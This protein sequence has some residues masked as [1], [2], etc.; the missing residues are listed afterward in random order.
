M[1]LIK[2]WILIPAA[3]AALF[4]LPL[5]CASAPEQ[6]AE[7][8]VKEAVTETQ[9]QTTQG[10]EKPEPTSE[11]MEA[12]KKTAL[13][14]REKAVAAKAPKAVKELFTEGEELMASAESFGTGKDYTNAAAEYTKAA[15]VFED[16]STQADK[17]RMEAI[18]A[19]KAAD[20]AI[21]NVEKNADEAVKASSEGDQ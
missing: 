11:L 13:T 1:N 21:A 2:K 6:P 17:K 10:M 20:E 4:I 14:A 19:M 12:A 16:A 3:L 7:E 5:S 9:P 15:A 18:A 8:P